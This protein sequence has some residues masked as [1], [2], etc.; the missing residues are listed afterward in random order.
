MLVSVLILVASTV[1]ADE[2]SDRIVENEKGN[3][4][5][6]SNVTENTVVENIAIENTAIENKVS[7]SDQL[8]SEENDESSEVDKNIEKT[9]YLTGTNTDSDTDTEIEPDEYY[10]GVRYA[11]HVQNIGWQNEVSDGTTSG[12]TGRGLQIELKH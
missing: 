1:Y 9:G 10:I 5:V 6:D 7:S 8:S 12:T 4:E 3:L 2:L 11:A